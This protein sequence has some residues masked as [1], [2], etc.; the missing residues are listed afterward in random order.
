MSKAY[1]CIVEFDNGYRITNKSLIVFTNNP[2]NI[3]DI[4]W[5]ILC[6]HN[7]DSIKV[8]STESVELPKDNYGF[9][10]GETKYE[11]F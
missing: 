11:F 5:N 1:R 7:D 2:D 3:K 9:V 4:C 6:K 8:L 10:M